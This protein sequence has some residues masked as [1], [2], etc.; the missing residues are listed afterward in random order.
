MSI[1]P[2][3]GQRRRARIIG[4]PEYMSREQVEGIRR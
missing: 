4:T 3:W 2:R 1:K